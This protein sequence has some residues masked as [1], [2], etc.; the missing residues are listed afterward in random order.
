V[1]S[2]WRSQRSLPD[3]LVEHNVAGIE[4]LDTRAL[5]RRLRLHGAMRGMVTTGEASPQELVSMA[6][7]LPPMEGQNLVDL[8]TPA[9]PWVRDGQTPRAVALRPDGAY[10]WNGKGLPLAVMDYGIKWNIVRLLEDHGF[11]PLMLPARWS[12]EAVRATGAK[13]LFLSNGPGDPA[14]LVEEMAALRELAYELPTAAI[15]LGH[16]L[17]GRVFGGATRKLKFGHHGCNH[18]VKDLDSGR[19]EI[20]PQDHG[21]CV[22]IAGIP[23]IRVTHVNLNDAT[24]EGFAHEDLPV[25]A[26]QHHPEAAPGRLDRRD[27]FF[28]RFHDLACA[29]VA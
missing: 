19:V 14:A 24:H 25:I 27:F 1:P 6:R 11:E 29:A 12:A 8:V 15:C 7:C 22:D 5:V 21:F 18:P 2:N 13:A 26:V 17:L 28:A 16:Q 23:G 20:S 4:G 3:F 10:D 9:Q